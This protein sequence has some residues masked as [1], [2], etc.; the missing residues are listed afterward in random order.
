MNCLFMESL[1]LLNFMNTDFILWNK[2]ADEIIV[3]VKFHGILVNH[4]YNP[5]ALGLRQFLFD[6]SICPRTHALWAPVKML[7]QDEFRYVYRQNHLQIRGPRNPE[8]LGNL[9]RK[10]RRNK[11]HLWYI[12]VQTTST[13]AFIW[14]HLYLY[15]TRKSV[16]GEALQA[17]LFSASTSLKKWHQQN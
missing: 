10:I 17:Q 16:Y 9:V 11:L 7:L 8:A 5:Y 3:P 15:M 1:L 4:Y 6:I 14:W 2:Y 12:A 13:S